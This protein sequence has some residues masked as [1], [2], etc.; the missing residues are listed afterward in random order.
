MKDALLKRRIIKVL[1]E[2]F[3]LKKIYPIREAF[4]G[5]F[6]ETKR[7]LFLYKSDN[8]SK[9][10]ERIDTLLGDCIAPPPS[11]PREERI[12]YYVDYDEKS[13]SSMIATAEGR[14][15]L[16]IGGF[17]ETIGGKF[18]KMWALYG[19]IISFIM[20]SITGPYLVEI[21]DFFRNVL[22]V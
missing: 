7:G 14:E 17:I 9:Y 8:E 18:S 22:K 10:T 16:S 4:V 1:Y 12:K 13:R 5:Y 20:G 3:N 2:D 19:L 6:V 11:V 15:F 21:I